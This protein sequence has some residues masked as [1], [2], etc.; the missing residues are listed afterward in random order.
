MRSARSAVNAGISKAQQ[1]HGFLGNLIEG[2]DEHQQLLMGLSAPLAEEEDQPTLD[3][4]RR[5]LHQ[6]EASKSTANSTDDL[7]VD[8]A[9]QLG[10]L[11]MEELDSI[12]S[13]ADNVATRLARDTSKRLK[14][15]G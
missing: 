9:E 10:N 15:L 7:A 6:H 12:V 1:D 11:E 4:S 3:T 2:I 8:D 5:E 13:L 14:K